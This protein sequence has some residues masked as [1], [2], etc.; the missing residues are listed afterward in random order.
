MVQ[1]VPILAQTQVCLLYV[2]YI[3]ICVYIKEIYIT[4][5]YG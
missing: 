3:N 5:I 2:V 1:R 4:R